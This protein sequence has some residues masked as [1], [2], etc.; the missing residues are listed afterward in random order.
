MKRPTARH[1]KEPPTVSYFLRMPK[2]MLV[3]YST[4]QLHVRQ[5]DILIRVHFKDLQWWALQNCCIL[6]AILLCVIQ[7]L[8]LRHFLGRSRKNKKVK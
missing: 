1:N 4:I 5:C 7:S 8:F 3:A 2:C 6:K